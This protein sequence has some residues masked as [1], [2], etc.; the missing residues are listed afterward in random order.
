MN[1]LAA[2]ISASAAALGL[3]FPF[4]AVAVIAFEARASSRWRRALCC[5][6]RRVRRAAFSALVRTA[7]QL[8]RR[9]DVPPGLG[10]FIVAL[11]FEAGRL[12]RG[13]GDRLVTVRFQELTRVVLDF[14]FPHY[15]GNLL[16]CSAA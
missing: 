11:R 12:L 15:H 1:C 7:H 5:T 4:A 10:L 3:S 8:E 6:C 9:L 13:F 14:D 16:F 2:L